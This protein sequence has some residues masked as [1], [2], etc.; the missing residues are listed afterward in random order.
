MLVDA[1]GV[2]HEPAGRAP[3]IVCLV[4]SITELLFAL[5]L[6]DSVVGRTAFCVHPR[7]G[8]DGVPRVGGTKTVRLDK[9]RALHPTHVIVNVDEN[10]KEQVEEIAAFGSRVVVTHPSAPRD[11]LDLYRLLGGIFDRGA[12]AETLCERFERQYE[13]VL[14]LRPTWPD[15]W[16]LY[17][18]WRSPWMSIA[19]ST[20]IGQ[21]LALVG[22]RTIFGDP[23]PRYPE[24]HPLAPNLEKV[25]L[26]LFGSEPFP[27]K[28]KHMREFQTLFT[29]VRA[30]C[31]PI[32]GELVSWYGSRA[33]T[34]L[35][36]LGRLATDLRG[37]GG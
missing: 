15:R 26:V 6:A 10:R 34:G 31:A 4:P 32:D 9:L 23:E 27:F 7:G 17:L 22:L 37:A 21:M 8:I 28:I 13:E 18:I 20:Y 1:A 14:R 36:Y 2:A 3:R 16:V 29:R 30:R 35:E 19:A 12:A 5:G 33:I 25:D 24:V 11:N